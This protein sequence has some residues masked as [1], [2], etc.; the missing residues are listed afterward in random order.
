MNGE[1]IIIIDVNLT[2]GLAVVLVVGLLAIALLGYLTFGHEEAAASSPKTTS[3]GSAGMRQFYLSYLNIYNGS[4]ADTACATDYHF[5][6][7]WEILDPSNLKYNTVLG[8]TQGDSGQGP[9]SVVGWVRTGNY[10]HNSTSTAGGA[11]CSAWT[12]T[13]GY[14]TSAGLVSNWLAGTEDVYVWEVFSAL[15]A[16]TGRVW[17]VED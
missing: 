6:S 8:Y 10:S 4:N 11:N 2:R 9:P 7:L 15:C 13:S 16:G 5:A 3:Q 14:G 12:T 17:C 1:K